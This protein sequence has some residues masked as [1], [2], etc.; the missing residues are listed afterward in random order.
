MPLSLGK[1]C[2]KYWRKN[3]LRKKKTPFLTDK[4]IKR[5]YKGQMW[6][7]KTS[8]SQKAFHGS[9]KGQWVLCCVISFCEEM[10]YVL[11]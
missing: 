1:F 6:H 5:V 7:W 10:T 4:A 9:G 3:N 8:Y 11:T 2:R